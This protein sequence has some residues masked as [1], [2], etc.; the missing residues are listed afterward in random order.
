M[1]DYCMEDDQ[2]IDAFQRY[3]E[4]ENP[5]YAIMLH[6]SWGCGKTYYA[7]DVGKKAFKIYVNR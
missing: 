4:T 6:G 2:L 3:F 5:D 1:Y 7:K